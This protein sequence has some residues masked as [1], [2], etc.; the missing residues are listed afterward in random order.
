MKMPRHGLMGAVPAATSA[1]NFATY[2]RSFPH[3]R[4]LFMSFGST[5]QHST[6]S[7]GPYT[8]VRKQKKV[9]LRDLQKAHQQGNKIAMLTAYDC[10]MGKLA[11]DSGVD[12]VL[13]GDSVA[14]VRLGYDSTVEISM[15]EMLMV[16]KGV[17]RGLD[18]YCGPGKIPL[19][20]GDMPFGSYL[21][22]ADALHNA[23][24]LLKDGRADVVKLEGGNAKAV[25]TARA[26]VD[27]GIG[28]MGHVGLTPQTH[29]S[30]GGYRQQAVQAESALQLLRE[31]EALQEAGC[32]A[33]VF[34]CVPS[35]V[36]AF[37]TNQL[38]TPTI[39]IGAGAGT[40]GQVLVCDDM[41]GASG[42]AVPSFVKKYAELAELTQSAIRQYV[43]EVK[44]GS[45]PTASHSKQMS[46][47]ELKRLYG[48]AGA[49]D[50]IPAQALGPRI[51]PTPREEIAQAPSVIVTEA[52]SDVKFQRCGDSSTGATLG[53]RG[54]LVGAAALS[55]SMV[56]AHSEEPGCGNARV[57]HSLKDVRAVVAQAK[58]SGK[59]VGFVP[60]MGHLHEGHL[61][62]IDEAS[63]DCDFVIVSVF[64]NPS[65]FAAH[66]DFDKYPRHLDCDVATLNK[67]GKTHVVFAPS[68]ADMYPRDPRAV[69]LSTAVVPKAV[70][71][72]P[73]D[74]QRPHF[75]TGV[76]TVCAKLF[77][78]VQPDAVFFGQK[79]AVQCVVIRNLIEDLC[80]PI[81]FNVVPTARASDGLALSSRNA[82]L[83]PDQRVRAP[84]VY[85]ALRKGEM[86]LREH[87][88]H[89]PTKQLSAVVR[90]VLESERDV[91]VQYIDVSGL[92][93]MRPLDAVCVVNDGRVRPQ[94]PVVVSVGL[95][96]G[97]GEQVVRLI[98]N[99]VVQ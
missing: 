50:K 27:A 54:A 79:D 32:F 99:I 48:L 55:V 9:G 45:F 70:V 31:A 40:T 21:T 98:D 2:F 29:V 63:T 91:K 84:V 1:D 66:E 51:N 64:V 11:A 59:K 76:A 5:R 68:A 58:Q 12:I 3:R 22:V 42:A 34:E 26:L 67:H 37:V 15:D 62:L 60:T 16:T 92:I 43:H 78:I 28:V 35:E 10:T 80:L 20:V 85:R 87:P 19:L 47:A 39:G 93:D 69:T 18:A 46:D 4:A 83:T 6:A 90:E 36:A 71:G 73:E 56:L 24:R 75:F 7:E 53:G 8:M 23:T 49:Q 30:L 13:V 38:R 52:H 81:D 25:E 86:L 57:I 82:Y 61:Q 94:S 33:I 96:M 44:D 17:R 14:N 72:L 74:S 95:T 97:Y 89:V 88:G 41:L 65:Q 77:N